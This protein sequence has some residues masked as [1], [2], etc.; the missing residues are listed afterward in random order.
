M[1][2]VRLYRGWKTVKTFEGGRQSKRVRLI[3]GTDRRKKKIVAKHFDKSDPNQHK[4]FEKEVRNYGLVKGCTFV[5][6]L[7]AVDK[8]ELIL[9]LEYCGETPSHYTPELKKEVLHHVKK[10][11]KRYNLTRD[12]RY[13]K[14]GLPRL[15]NVAV[16]HQKVKLIDLGPPFGIAKK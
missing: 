9:Y 6:K 14:E 16:R 8:E 2:R 11:R 12:F 3:E 15:A 1:D 13:N 5:P 7:L 10:L 4:A